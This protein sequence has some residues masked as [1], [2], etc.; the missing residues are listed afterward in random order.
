M[1]LHVFVKNVFAPI[2]NYFAYNTIE[3]HATALHVL[4]QHIPIH[5]Y[6]VFLIGKFVEA[7]CYMTDSKY[8]LLIY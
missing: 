1:S 2:L 8:R 7:H 6:S 5:E 4:G 3:Y